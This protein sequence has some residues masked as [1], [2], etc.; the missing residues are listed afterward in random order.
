M[1]ARR[2]RDERGSMSLELAIL[3][4]GFLALAVLLVAAGHLP[5]ARLNVDGAAQDAARAATL[6]TSATQARADAR[7]T[8]EESLAR[9]HVSCADLDVDVDL[10]RFAP[11]GDVTVTVQCRVNLTWLPVVGAH[12]P[13]RV[14]G[15]VNAPMDVYQSEPTL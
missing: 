1:M 14:G 6:A 7:R 2:R 15:S 11:G 5:R 9:E 10:A 3:T 8:A 12:L 4:P 13:V